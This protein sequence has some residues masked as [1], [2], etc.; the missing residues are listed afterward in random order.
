[1]SVSELVSILSKYWGYASF[2]PLQVEALQM[3]LSGRD[4]MVIMSTGSGKSILYQLPA[5]LLREQGVKAVSVVVSPLLSLIEDQV[6]SLSAMG[7]SVGILGGNSSAADELRA[8][9]GEYAILYCTPEKIL[10]W[11]CGLMKLLKNN[12]RVCCLAVDEAHCVSEWGHDFRPSYRRLG[13][14]RNLLPRGVPILALTATATPIVERD[15]ISSLELTNV[16]LCRSSFNRPNLKYTVRARTNSSDLLKLLIVQN[17]SVDESRSFPSTLIYVSTRSDAEELCHEI[18]L[19]DKL[20]CH[21]VA[22]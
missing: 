5:L 18:K 10:N 1:M 4:A 9:Q 3:I 8:L 22:F 19:Q 21:G 12:V 7:V 2:R 15:V 6:L 17:E 16:F 13:E 20:R 14:I 11:Q